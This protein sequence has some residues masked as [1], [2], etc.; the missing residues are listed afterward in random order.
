[1]AHDHM[2]DHAGHSHAGHSHAVRADAD[3]GKLTFA[4]ALIVAFMGVEVGVG[5]VAHSL[6]LLSDAGHMLTDA[7]AIGFS[8][9]A[10]SLAAR[11]ARGAMTFGFRRVE[12][13]SAQANGV[14]LLVLAAFIAYEAIRRLFDPPVVR[15]WLI[16]TV[17]LIGVLVNLLATWTLARANRE[18]L[19]VE[20]SFQHLLTDLY[21]FI[22]TAI[23]AGVILATGFQRADPIVSLLIAALM[24]RS[25]FAL[26]RASGRIFLEAAPEGLDPQ[27]IGK[28][29]VGAPGVV[30]VHDLHVWEISSGFPALSAHVLV[31]ADSDCHAARRA[32]EAVLHERFALDH[33]TLQV[34][35]AGGELL[36]I[37][38]VRGSRGQS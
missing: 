6:A 15:G 17:A 7:A 4:L 3:R 27:A 19:N 33:T 34:D 5:V 24:T 29:L 1:M 36:E 20:G 25:G 16:L 22:G 31:R 9:L 21:G 2:P 11:P 37:E 14:T 35:H 8:L 23:A 28:A 10:I 13:L 18:S 38:P 12:I 26:V 32:M 30:E